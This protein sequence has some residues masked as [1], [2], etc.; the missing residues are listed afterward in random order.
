MPRSRSRADNLTRPCE[1]R[2]LSRRRTS[3]TGAAIGILSPGGG[4]IEDRR[5]EIDG[6]QAGEH[7][8]CR[9]ESVDID[10]AHSADQFR[11]RQ[12]R[13]EQRVTADFPEVKPQ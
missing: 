4:F 13:R 9:G 1:H 5:G 7:P 8:T 11:P 10:A 2:Y 12:C 6:G 3:Q